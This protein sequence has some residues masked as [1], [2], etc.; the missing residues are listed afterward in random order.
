MSNVGES[1]VDKMM[2]ERE[3]SDKALQYCESLNECAVEKGRVDFIEV[4]E[5]K[6]YCYCLDEPE[7][8]EVLTELLLSLLS[9]PS[10]LMRRVVSTLFSVICQHLTASALDIILQVC[11]R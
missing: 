4:K 6:V 3:F 10:Q 11:S 2:I 7:W 1:K 5:G 8:I 9:R